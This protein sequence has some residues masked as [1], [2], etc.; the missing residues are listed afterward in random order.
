[1]ENPLALGTAVKQKV[2]VI[3]GTVVDVKFDADSGSFQYLVEHP[4]HEGTAS[5]RWFAA[6]EVV[7]ADVVPAS[8][9]SKE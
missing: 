5:T 2:E 3:E 8:T 4:N 6:G 1:M 7:A 9:D